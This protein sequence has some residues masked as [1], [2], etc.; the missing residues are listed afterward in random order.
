MPQQL[1]KEMGL[2]SVAENSECQW[3]VANGRR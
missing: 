2:E 1:F 3:R